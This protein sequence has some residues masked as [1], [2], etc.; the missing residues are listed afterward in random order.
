VT[1]AGGGHASWIDDPLTVFGSIRE[2]L[3]GGWPLG[4]ENLK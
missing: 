2:F 4:A 3:R 1:I